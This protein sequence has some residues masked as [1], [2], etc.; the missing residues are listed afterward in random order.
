M[1]NALV[2]PYVYL[3]VEPKYSNKAQV[4]KSDFIRIKKLGDIMDTIKK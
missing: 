1:P 4:D 3:Q 2:N